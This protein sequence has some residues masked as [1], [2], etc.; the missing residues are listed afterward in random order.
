MVSSMVRTH[1]RAVDQ[2]ERVDIRAATGGAGLTH[3]EAPRPVGLMG[4]LRR[5]WWA[6]PALIAVA[7]RLWGAGLVYAFGATSW[8]AFLAP[9]AAGPAT[10]WDGAWYLSIARSGYH[11]APLLLSDRGGYHDF[12]FWPAWP[13]VLAPIVRLVPDA[14][15]DVSAALAANALAVVALVLWAR[16]LEPAFGRRDARYAIAFVGFAPSA[17]ILSMAYSEPL[18]LLAAAAF[19]LTRTESRWRPVL[20]ALAQATRVTGFAVAASV[21]PELARTRGRDR[22]LWLTLAA[23]LLVFAGWWLFIAVLTGDPAGF[24]QGTPSWLHVTGQESGPASFL[25]DIARDPRYARPILIWAVFMVAMVVGALRLFRRGLPQFGW[26]AVAALLPTLI[27]ASWQ[28]M[29]RHALLAVP[30]VAAVIQPLPD[31]LR[32]PL[33]ALSILAE[34]VVAESMVGMRLISP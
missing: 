5:S 3:E 20:A 19:F 33:L 14:W 7:S 18:F 11:A 32:W 34:I 4:S 6:V 16:V 8:P 30:A 2:N 28:S 1:R 23:P 17:F 27:F 22:R 25:P 31:R 21:L 29:P 15:V 24:L 12:A 10:T 13:G 9:P 26:Y